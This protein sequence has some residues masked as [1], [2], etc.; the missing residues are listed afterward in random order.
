VRLYFYSDGSGRLWWFRRRLCLV[1]DNFSTASCNEIPL[2]RRGLGHVEA[3]Q[4]RDIVVGE[5][6]VARGGR[7]GQ[8]Q[9]G[10]DGRDHVLSVDAAKSEQE[11]RLGVEPRA[12]L[13]Q[14]KC[15][16]RL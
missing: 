13:C 10:A 12:G 8:R 9:I 2:R 1:G 4:G 14:T 15:S 11:V 16:R 6:A 7:R 5:H 3:E